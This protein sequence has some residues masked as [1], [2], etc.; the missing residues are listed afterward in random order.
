MARILHDG[1]WYEQLSTAALYEED[2]E[3]LLF[4]HG[5]SLF[6]SYHL[7]PFKM[8]VYSESAG[9]KADFALVHKN[10]RDWW[11]VEVEL[12]HHSFESHVRPQV[13]TL[14]RA[15]YDEHAAA[16][17][18][19]KNASL[20]LTKMRSVVK[21]EQPKILV[22]V[23]VPSP[24]WSREL[25]H[26]NALTSV[27]EVFRSSFNKHL[28]RLN[29]EQPT[30]FTTVASWCS[31][32]LSRFLRISSPGIL[33]VQHD[34]RMD[35]YF[36]DGITNWV[37]TDLQDRVYLSTSNPVSLNSKARYELV[38]REDSSFALLEYI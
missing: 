6:P 28:Y 30:E 15:K 27:F 4:Q 20:D 35:I 33:P 23:N 18:C 5:E 37:R 38:S 25:K 14:S 12:G 16:Y 11:V 1:E 21:G 10:Y 26:F 29:G 2:Y 36:R 22:V 31:V 13:E 32:E 7:V 3:R 34:E 24:Q 17:L 8:T 9:A 19:S